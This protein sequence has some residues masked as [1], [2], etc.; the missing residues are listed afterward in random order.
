MR[1][2]EAGPGNDGQGSWAS[3][4]GSRG[5]WWSPQLLDGACSIHSCN[6]VVSTEVLQQGHAAQGSQSSRVQIWTFM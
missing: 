6:P 3:G 5:K 4:L 1:G 2:G